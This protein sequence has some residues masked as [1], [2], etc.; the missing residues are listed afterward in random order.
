MPALY[1]QSAIQI[2]SIHFNGRILTGGHSRL[3]VRLGLLWIYSKDIFTG[4]RALTVGTKSRIILCGM[5]STIVDGEEDTEG[6][7][8]PL[9]IIARGAVGQAET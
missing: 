2:S 6:R 3:S 7:Y 5:A 4:V 8:G 9:E 1:G